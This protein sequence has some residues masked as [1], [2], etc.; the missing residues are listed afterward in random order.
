MSL[1]PPVRDQVLDAGLDELTVSIDGADKETFEKL[2]SGARLET[3]V[4]N[5]RALQKEKR[6]RNLQKPRILIATAVSQHNVHQLG[7]I[8][9]L[10]HKL[11]AS[12]IVFTD[13]IL[14][15][16]KQ[17]CLSVARTDLFRKNFQKAEALGKKYGIDVLYFYQYP[18][19]WKKDPVPQTRIQGR[20]YICRD[21][22]KTCIINR[23]G[24]MKPCCYYPPFT[25]NVFTHPLPDLINN[26][27][28]RQLRRR[29]LEGD[30]PECCQS[31]GILT[32]INAEQS[33]NALK[34]AQ[35][36]FLQSKDSSLLTQKDID[37]LAA[38]LSEYHQLWK[39]YQD[40]LTKIGVRL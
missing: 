24:N 34:Q 8:V 38:I 12:R 25:G 27:A 11:E 37:E 33:L 30:P 13:L 15:D 28:N 21:A 14:V 19:P 36:L 26:E 10:G 4:E 20:R 7:D 32:E 39:K 18:F 17:A 6:L 23:R 29:L 35:T 5:V 16:E 9:K 31:C 1:K 3:V 2:R 22:W 40:E